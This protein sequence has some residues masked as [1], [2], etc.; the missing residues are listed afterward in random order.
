MLRH[1]YKKNSWSYRFLSL[2]LHSGI[3]QSDRGGSGQRRELVGPHYWW[4]HSKHMLLS[5]GCF[6]DSGNVLTKL[7]PFFLAVLVSSYL[8]LDVDPRLGSVPIWSFEPGVHYLLCRGAA[9]PFH[10]GNCGVCPSHSILPFLSLLPLI[11]WSRKRRYFLLWYPCFLDPN[12]MAK[13]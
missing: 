10:G 11:P 13:P 5:S 3:G 6:S 2:S 1:F 7:W 9:L 4:G 8:L 12:L